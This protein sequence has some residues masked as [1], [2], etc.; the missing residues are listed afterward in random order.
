MTLARAIYDMTRDAHFRAKQY[1]IVSDAC[2]SLGY[3][4][5][6]S[7]IEA[8]LDKYDPPQKRRA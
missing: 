5:P 1:T 2:A 4:P 7:E 8:I 6:N 3:V